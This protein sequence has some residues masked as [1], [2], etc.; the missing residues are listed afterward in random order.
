M[1]FIF[2]Q[3]Q[4]RTKAKEPDLVCFTKTTTAFPYLVDALQH[5]YPCCDDS[6]LLITAEVE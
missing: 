1:F 5:W 2:L 6:G 4:G 3:S